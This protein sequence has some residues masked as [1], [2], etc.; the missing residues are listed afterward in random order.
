[1]VQEDQ[2]EQVVA[3]VVLGAVGTTQTVPQ[4]QAIP[5]PQIQLKATMVA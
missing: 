4:G 5:H 2:A 1:M 3:R